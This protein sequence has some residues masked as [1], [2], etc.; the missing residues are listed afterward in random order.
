VKKVDQ[1]GQKG[2]K[3]KIWDLITFY[4]SIQAILIILVSKHLYWWVVYRKTIKS[5]KKW[6]KQVKNDQKTNFGAFIAFLCQFS[7]VFD[8]FGIKMF[9][10][11][12]SL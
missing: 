3:T 4:L 12:S 9:V 5:E 11:M 7:S 8:H 10:L 2:P 1:M 6:I